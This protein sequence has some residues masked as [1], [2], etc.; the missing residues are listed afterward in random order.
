MNV[1][2]IKVH[3]KSKQLRFLETLT[4]GSRYCVEVEGG[5]ETCGKDAALILSTPGGVQVA[6]GTLE[7]GA[8]TLNLNCD[9]MLKLEAT[10]PF[11]TVLVLNAV[12]RC[13][14]EGSEQTVALGQCQVIASWQ[15]TENPDTGTIVYYKGPPGESF[16][17][18]DLTD[19]QKAE[20]IEAAAQAVTGVGDAM[21]GTTVKTNTVPGM[22]AAIEAI[23]R[24]LGATVALFML[25]LL[26]AFGANVSSAPLNDLDFDRNPNVVTNVSLEGLATT[27]ALMEKQDVIPDLETIRSGAAAG[28]TALQ[29]ESDPTVPAW[30]KSEDKPVYDYSE[31]TGKPVIPGTTS[32]LTNDSGFITAADLPRVD[33]TKLMT[34]DG[35]IW[36]D[37]TGCVWQVTSEDALKYIVVDNVKYYPEAGTKRFTD[38]NNS[39]FFIETNATKM[40][41]TESYGYYGGKWSGA[42]T[43][44]DENIYLNELVDAAENQGGKTATVVYGNAFSTNLIGRVATESG[45]SNELEKVKMV[46][47]SYTAFV[48]GSNV[49][50]SITNYISGAY[51]LD[52]AKLKILELREGEYREVY[53]SRDEI[54]LHVTNASAKVESAVNSKIENL[55]LSLRE[56]I[57]GKADKAWGRYTSSGGEAPSN[58]VYMTAPNTVFAGGMEYQRVA[59]GEGMISVLTTKGAPVY[60]AGDEGT[61]KFQDDGGTNYF[62]FAKT[63]SYTVGCDTD[64]IVV[65][66]QIVTLTYNIEMSGV[67]CIWY[68][69]DLSDESW[70]QLNLADGSAAN[71]API[72]VSWENDPEVGTEVCYIN[73]GDKPQGF[74]RATVEVVG[75]AKFITNMP[76]DLAGGILCTDGITK[77]QPVKQTDGSIKWEVIE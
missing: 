64:G 36:Q 50:F 41:Y 73:V 58:T 48:D 72:A 39:Y 75:S 69:A 66:D 21:K 31:L 42:F 1:L 62:G 26:P 27:E 24:A 55:E 12:L 70:V 43:L 11:G 2:K 59:V 19:E 30:A 20:L 68:K 5:E 10:V 22:R 33:A 15:G 14:D 54:V 4:T 46:V 18:E 74:F 25:A 71:G 53:N 51:Y 47:T 23:A 65:S 37:A 6:V 76:A 28:A 45:V 8:G 29:V 60:T 44:G 9:A 52:H 7:S 63:D 16:S 3:D 34:E 49:V 67:P 17:W 57:S 77:I 13:F 38:P 35:M 40:T 32:A 56:S 61:F